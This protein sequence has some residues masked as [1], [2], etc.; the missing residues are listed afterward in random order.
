MS[1]LPSL[2][3]QRE[4]VTDTDCVSLSSFPEIYSKPSSSVSLCSTEDSSYT[5]GY[6]DSLSHIDFLNVSSFYVSEIGDTDDDRRHLSYHVSLNS[7]ID[8]VERKQ[9]VVRFEVDVNDYII[10][11]HYEYP[12]NEDLDVYTTSEEE[13]ENQRLL[14]RKIR[15]LQTQNRGGLIRRL[16]NIYEYELCSKDPTFFNE[17]CSSELRGFESTFLYESSSEQYVKFVVTYYNALQELITNNSNV[18]DDID[19]LLRDQII[20]ISQKS[21]DFAENIAISDEAEAI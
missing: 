19:E 5:Q 6:D 21:R 17:W 20:F 3:H 16:N 14:D 12:K 11:Y 4:Q 8:F 15:R 18:E 9:N 13:D 2:N 7:N 10:E 1:C